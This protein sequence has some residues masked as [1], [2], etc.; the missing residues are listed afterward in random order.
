MVPSTWR[1]HGVDLL[2]LAR[3]GQWAK[4]LVV[5]APLLFAGG[6]VWHEASTGPLVCV[7]ALGA[8]MAFTAVA[9]AVYCI[10]DAV[11][12]DRDRLHVRNRQ[13]PVAAGR[14]SARAAVLVSV[15]WM[16]L[17]TLIAAAIDV[18]VAAL[19]VAYVALML[20]YSFGLKHIAGLDVMVVAGGFVLRFVTGAVALAVPVSG[21]LLV[22][23]AAAAVFVGAEKRRAAGPSRLGGDGPAVA[24]AMAATYAPRALAALSLAAL[25]VTVL[26]YS[27][28]ASASAHSLLW[29]TALVVP[30]GLVR[31][32]GVARRHPER[33]ADQL[34]GRD[35]PLLTGAL[36][37]T[38]GVLI[39]VSMG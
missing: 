38:I 26:A 3:P 39:A 14:V 15:G 33:N 1:R 25:C 16:S 23:T 21:W 11:D 27:A 12:R 2:L 13:R 8:A 9:A 7:R 5:L 22:S 34:I 24:R 31:Y 29:L 37:F 17:G 19:L 28:Y 10:N 4:N 36:A 32:R 6:A 18:R 35:V 30:F 20:G